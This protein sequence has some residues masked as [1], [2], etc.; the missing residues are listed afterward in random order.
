[1]VYRLSFSKNRK[2]TRH[3]SDP[4]V[5][6]YSVIL[7]FE[8]L[9]WF[10]YNDDTSYSSLEPLVRESDSHA[11]LL[12]ILVT[13]YESVRVV[14]MQKQALKT[15]SSSVVLTNKVAFITSGINA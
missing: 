8:K 6:V 9:N 1:M 2:K 11:F 4:V 3:G 15:R 14:G 10:L 12:L 7:V 13:D 5:S